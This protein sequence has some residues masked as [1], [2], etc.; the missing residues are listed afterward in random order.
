M[1]QRFYSPIPREFTN[2]GAIGA[3]WKY[4]FYTTGTTTPITTYSNVTLATPNANPVVADSNGRFSEIFVSDFSLVKAVLKDDLGNTIWTADPVNPSG[5]SSV[6]LNDLGV[7]PTSYWGLT[8][9]TA[10]AYTMVANPTISAYSNNQTFIFQAHI[11]NS[12]APTLAIDGLT[13]LNLKKYTGQGTKIAIQAGDLQATERYLAINDGADIVIL[14]PRN[15][16][17]YLGTSAALT[18]ATGVA[19]I[20]NGGSLYAIDTEGATATDDLDTI[21]GGNQGEV[22]IIG[23][24]ND[25]RNVVLKHNTGNIYNP[26]GI[27][28]TLDVTSDRVTLM[29]DSTLAKWIVIGVNAAGSTPIQLLDTKT[30]SNS[31][32][33]DFTSG[34]N[35]T[36]SKYR[37]EL[38]NIVPASNGFLQLQ[39]SINGGSSWITSNYTNIATYTDAG[40]TNTLVNYNNTA[41]ALLSANNVVSANH[42]VHTDA[43][44]GIVGAVEISNTSSSSSYKNINFFVSYLAASTAFASVRGSGRYIGGTQAVTALR[45]VFSSGNITSGIFKLYGII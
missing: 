6:T 30:A 27:N 2:S 21:N 29:Y 10:A 25:A 5:S 3:G 26:G 33:I 28:I 13:A 7:R 11:A 19:T 24:A 17:T 39:Y 35:S 12:A 31:T 22:I 14:N 42:Y 34:I 15:Q 43:P 8:A 16:T 9:G 44:S 4:Y 1:A 41:A 32:S 38:I 45:F 37:I 23:N 36:Y 40:T 18:I 20:T